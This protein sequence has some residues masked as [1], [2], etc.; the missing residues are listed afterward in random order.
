[1]K[2]AILTLFIL[3]LPFSNLH[4]SDKWTKQDYV[5]EITWEV[6]HL[7]DWSQTRYIAEHPDKYWEINPILG[8][9]PSIE[10]V[11][12]YMGAGAIVHPIISH[13]LPRKA[14][15]LWMDNVYWYPRTT[16]QS[17]TITMSG[18]AVINNLS[19]GIKCEF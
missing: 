4:A 9:H 2:R 14:K 8:N 1:M 15:F 19:I 11:D 3:L 13:I 17:I 18:S 12:L 6:L 5:L 7:I 10:K 16:W